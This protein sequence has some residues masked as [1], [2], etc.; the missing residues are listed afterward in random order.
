MPRSNRKSSGFLLLLALLLA[1]ELVSRARIVNPVFLPPLTS[2]LAALA[3]LAFSGELLKHIG[4][5]LARCFC[6]Y[7]LA[8]LIA[9]PI[10]IGMGYS[11]TL[12]N[13]LEPLVEVLRPLR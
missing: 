5:T 6:G 4:Y 12:Y 1:W 13:L 8:C 3:R 2:I 11:R 9:I 7:A 10:G